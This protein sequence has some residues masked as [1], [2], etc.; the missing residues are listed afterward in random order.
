MKNFLICLSLAFLV[1]ACSDNDKTDDAQPSR[2]DGPFVAMGNGQANA[3]LTVDAQGNPASLGFTLSKGALDQLPT[4]L[5]ATD[6]MLALPNEAVQKTPFKH[7]MIGWN[8]M[9]HEPD[10]IYNVPH[11][12][13]H[14]Y[15]MPMNLV[16]QIP[17]Y[18]QN[19]AA[20][21]NQ[22][23]A[24][25]L[26]VG[27]VKGPGGV[28]GMGAHW[29]DVSSPEFRGEP[30]TETFVYGSYDGHVTFWEPMI[31][32]SYLKTNPTLDKAIKQPAQYE[33]PGFYPTRYSI[34]AK[35]DGSY[36]VALN[37]FVKR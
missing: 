9:G 31:A 6:F 37:Q 22:P 28:P 32:M 12:D 24:A 26:P 2:F 14:F 27:Y 33:Q 8:P 13:T 29:T 20:F 23:A 10:G 7:I 15:M 5:P 21:D 18:A 35:A 36:E 1:G 19:P 34:Q 25:Y 30:F 17:P 16:M 4:A 3:W 11:F